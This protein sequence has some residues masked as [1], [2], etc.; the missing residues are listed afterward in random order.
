MS[1][2]KTE[3]QLKIIFFFFAG[4]LYKVKKDIELTKKTNILCMI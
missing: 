2:F 4:K 1:F 3:N